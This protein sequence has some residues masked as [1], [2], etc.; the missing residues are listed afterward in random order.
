RSGDVANTLRQS[1]DE[2]L[3][4]YYPFEETAPIPDDKLPTSRAPARRLSPPLLAPLTGGR[5]FGPPPGVQQVGATAPPGAAGADDPR[6][7]PGRGARPLPAD[8]VRT[9]LVFSP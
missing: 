2:A 3:M 5:G 8:L 9:A 1:I 7:A 4:A 6:R